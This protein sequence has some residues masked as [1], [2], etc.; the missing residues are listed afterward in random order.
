MRLDPKVNIDNKL[1]LFS[2][3]INNGTQLQDGAEM[4]ST[5]KR[6]NSG[7][8]VT[9]NKYNLF[10]AIDEPVNNLLSG[11]TCTCPANQLVADRINQISWYDTLKR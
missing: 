3:N 5:R 4:Y 2:E 11:K 8:Q 9:Q 1:A 7:I 6:R 10:S